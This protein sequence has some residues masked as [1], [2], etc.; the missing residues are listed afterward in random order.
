MHH[1][2]SWDE[3]VPE[4]RVKKLNEENLRRQ[5][6]LIE[7]QRQRD[8]AERAE[9]QKRALEQDATDKAA[10]AA[11]NSAPSPAP[12]AVKVPATAA[13][14][15]PA[16]TASGR[17]GADQGRGQKRARDGET[18]SQTRGG[19]LLDKWWGPSADELSWS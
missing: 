19:V 16:A 14:P 6:Q 4:E 7:A 1:P 18:V 17:R 13:P 5:K 8:A 11:A 9:L 15:A 10:A 3:W 12:V 2:L